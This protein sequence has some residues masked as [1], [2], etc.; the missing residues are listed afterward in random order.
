VLEGTA[1]KWERI[2]MRLH[3]DGNTISQIWTDSQH[4]Q[5]DACRN[6]FVEWLSG[7]EGLHT[8]R[9]WSTVIE[10]LKEAQLGQLADE[11]KDILG[12]MYV[13]Y[14]IHTV[15]RITLASIKFGKMALHWYWQEYIKR[16]RESI[17]QRIYYV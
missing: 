12:G 11:L 3:F 7:K 4:N 15:Q 17:E 10:V 5:L 2:A 13:Q 6:V 14:I 1:S 8:P 9:T 16:E